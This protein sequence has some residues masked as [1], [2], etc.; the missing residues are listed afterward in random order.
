M[1]Y[2]KPEMEQQVGNR[3]EPGFS[4]CTPKSPIYSQSL[5]SLMLRTRL[6]ALCLSGMHA[7]IE[8]TIPQSSK[9]QTE[10]SPCRWVTCSLPY[11]SSPLACYQE[12]L[13]VGESNFPAPRIYSMKTV[14]FTSDATR[15]YQN[16]GLILCKLLPESSLVLYLQHISPAQS[17]LLCS[18][19]KRQHPESGKVFS[20]LFP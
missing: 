17:D 1:S 20:D 14:S 2:S 15:S 10:K 16:W 18:A 11:W 3:L 9:P 4:R 19:G 6:R 5:L 8:L 13:N 12:N 7:T